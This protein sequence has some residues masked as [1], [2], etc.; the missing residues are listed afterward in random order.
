VRRAAVIAIVLACAAGVAVFADQF[1]SYGERPDPPVN[2]NVEYDGRLTFARMRYN[3]GAPGYYRARGSNGEPPWMHDY[4]TSDT[5]M[6]KI[7]KELT[8]AEP[9][10]DASNVLMLNDPALFDYPILYVSEPGYWTMSDEEGKCLRAYLLKGGFIMF[11]DFRDEHWYTLE[12]QMKRVLPDLRWI[13]IDASNTIFHSFFEIDDLR[14]LT[15]YGRH[16]PEYWVL[17][18]NNDPTKRVM[19]LA[20]FN[21]DIGE[22]W[23][24]SDTGIN[25]IDLSNEAYKYGVNYYIYGLIH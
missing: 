8:L 18:E 4:P 3:P 9:R 11:D 15:S 1:R 24:F 21:N 13:Q 25:P 20:N 7:L 10:T 22:Y 2:D 19:A 5:H 16:S 6:M 14:K 12:A 17:F 23:E